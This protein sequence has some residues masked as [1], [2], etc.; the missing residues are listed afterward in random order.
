MMDGCSFRFEPSRFDSDSRGVCYGFR[1]SA[2]RM[3]QF[4]G[5]LLRSSTL[6]PSLVEPPAAKRSSMMSLS[7]SSLSKS[8]SS[9]RSHFDQMEKS[10]LEIT[11]SVFFR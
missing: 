10:F 1:W 8:K 7:S 11:L 2:A 6:Q 5:N 4:E 3:D 9:W